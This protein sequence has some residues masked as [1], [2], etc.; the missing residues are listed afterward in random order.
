[1]TDFKSY[2]FLKNSPIVE[3]NLFLQFHNQINLPDKEQIEKIKADHKI[4]EIKNFN[5]D[6]SVIESN[7]GIKST[8]DKVGYRLDAGNDKS[9]IILRKSDVLVSFKNP[10][11]GWDKLQDTFLSILHDINYRD[12]I[13]P[14]L[15][16]CRFVNKFSLKM[17]NKF[18]IEDYFNF[19]INFVNSYIPNL[20][21]YSLNFVHVKD[22]MQANIKFSIQGDQKS[23]TASVLFDIEILKSINIEDYLNNK[24]DLKKIR[25]F[26]NYIFYESLTN[27]TINLFR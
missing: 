9:V 25:D 11:K 13:K 7:K 19:R 12:Q 1:L 18:R 27:N 4:S 22:D 23:E 2:E 8:I 15:I 17:E 14:K 10:Y 6:A 20:N 3:G 5:I 26:K 16:G 24:Y 21:A